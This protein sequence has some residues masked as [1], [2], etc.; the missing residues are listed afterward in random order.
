MGKEMQ[1]VNTERKRQ[2]FSKEFKLTAVKLLQAGQK[3]ATQL[4]RPVMCTAAHFHADQAWGQVSKVGGHL[5]A[6]QLFA[7]AHFAA[8]I[9]AV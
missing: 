3:P 1:K 4:A 2:K 9:H 7:H 5:G 6:L 8:L